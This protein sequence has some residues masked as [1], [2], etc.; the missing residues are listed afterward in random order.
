HL[1]F[2]EGAKRK[3]GVNFLIFDNQEMICNV[4][5]HFG[6]YER[7]RDR[8]EFTINNGKR[9]IIEKIS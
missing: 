5:H 6:Y 2:L 8:F 9:T 4:Q 3:E 7:E 1:N